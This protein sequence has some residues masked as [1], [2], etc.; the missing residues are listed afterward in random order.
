[1]RARA[2]LLILA[3]V[4]ASPGCGG[5]QPDSAAVVSSLGAVPIPSAPAQDPVAVAREDHLQVLAMGAPV[6]VVL[7]DGARARMTATGPMQ[8]STTAATGPDATTEATITLTVA[9][10]AGTVLLVAGDLSSRD[11]TGSGIGLDPDGPATIRVA[12]GTTGSLT[13]RGR[14]RS[15]AAQVTWTHDGHPIAVWD[16]NVEL[17]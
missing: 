16:F 8:T 13:V 6:D 5:G 7:A 1:M 3:A 10:T 17:D 15:G 2:A 11:D 9:A 4:L 14:F 12:A